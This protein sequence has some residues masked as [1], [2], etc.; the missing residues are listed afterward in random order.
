M[1]NKGKVVLSI[2]FLALAGVVLAWQLGAFKPKPKG[3]PETHTP[4]IV[5]R[6]QD[7][8][9]LTEGVLDDGRNIRGIRPG[10]VTIPE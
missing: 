4:D 9:G 10:G 7:D 3:A 2:V 8:Q 1:S 6:A 5:E